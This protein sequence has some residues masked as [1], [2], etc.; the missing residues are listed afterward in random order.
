MKQQD[1]YVLS[2]PAQQPSPYGKP[3]QQIMKLHYLQSQFKLVLQHPHFNASTQ[4]Q[5]R[6]AM[7]HSFSTG[8]LHQAMVQLPTPAII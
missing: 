1:V 8:E 5:S 4:L 3:Q 6:V 7:Q 2:V